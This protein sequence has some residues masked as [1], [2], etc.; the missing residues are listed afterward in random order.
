MK[1]IITSA[2]YPIFSLRIITDVRLTIDK[3]AWTKSLLHGKP[4]NIT[5]EG[6]INWVLYSA[7]T[8][9]D[10]LDKVK[11][12]YRNLWFLAGIGQCS[13][14]LCLGKCLRTRVLQKLQHT[15]TNRCRRCP[16]AGVNAH[17]KLVN[18]CQWSPYNTGANEI[19]STPYLDTLHLSSGL[20]H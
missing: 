7:P 10:P 13:H 1:D 5:A 8:D 15:E 2:K 19:H 14:V 9:T 6:K 18:I 3:T 20:F 12:R 11:N 17:L 4:T 16:E